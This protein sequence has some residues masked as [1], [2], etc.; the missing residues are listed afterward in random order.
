MCVYVN[1]EEVCNK[2][3]KKAKKRANSE[4]VLERLTRT[5]SHC[6]HRGACSKTGPTTALSAYHR[7]KT[8]LS[9]PTTAV[10]TRQ[11]YP[12]V[13]YTPRSRLSPCSVGRASSRASPVRPRGNC[14][15]SQSHRPRGSTLGRPLTVIPGYYPTSSSASCAASTRTAITP[16]ARPCRQRPFTTF[17]EFA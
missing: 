16:V 15:H 17:C 6:N 5:R 2:T 13:K 4:V 10:I 1:S 8:T 14:C 9:L 11:Y 3:R 12:L 7:S